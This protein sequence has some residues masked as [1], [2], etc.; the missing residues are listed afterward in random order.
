MKFLDSR[1]SGKFVKTYAIT[2]NADYEYKAKNNYLRFFVI[3]IEAS[4]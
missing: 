2:Q 1:K 4:I 3:N